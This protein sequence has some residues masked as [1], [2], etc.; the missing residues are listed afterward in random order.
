M[1]K[2]KRKGRELA[3]QAL[4]SLEQG[5]EGIE[6]EL[7]AIEEKLGFSWLEEEPAAEVSFYARTLVQGVANNL[8]QIDQRL[9][10]TLIKWELERICAIDRAILRIGIY[11][12]L[13]LNDT[14]SK[15]VLDECI[16]L[17]HKY[18]SDESYRLINGV[19]HNCLQSDS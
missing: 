2:E 15:L 14:P 17:A 12:L 6:L 8:Q 3:L 5:A 9:R 10:E 13:F 7:D 16:D 4:Y 18:A 1:Q 11:S 19:L